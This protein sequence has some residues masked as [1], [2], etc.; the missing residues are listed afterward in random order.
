MVS[1]NADDANEYSNKR[2]G[3]ETDLL[4]LIAHELGHVYHRFKFETSI[5]PREAAV[6]CSRT[7]YPLGLQH[8]PGQTVGS[9]SLKLYSPTT[10]L[11][12]TSLKYWNL[13]Q[14]TKLSCSRLA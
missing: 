2:Y 1:F 11:S 8:L 10:A 13:A 6:H 3:L 12:R 5:L 4:T 14:V 9:Q 7:K